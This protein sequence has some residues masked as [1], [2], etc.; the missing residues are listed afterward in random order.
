MPR[1]TDEIMRNSKDKAIAV[2]KGTKVLAS[3]DLALA[4]GIEDIVRTNA[5]RFGYKEMQTPTVCY[6][7]TL[8]CK[9]SEGAELADEIYSLTDRGERALGLRYDLTV[10][11]ARYVAENAKSLVFP[12]KRFECGEVFR[13]GPVKAG[14]MREFAQCDIDCVMQGYDPVVALDQIC[15]AFQVFDTMGMFDVKMKFSSRM[16]TEGILRLLEVGNE[17]VPAVIRVMDK[18]DKLSPDAFAAE[19]IDAGL[20]EEKLA[21]LNRWCDAPNAAALQ[22][23]RD[24]AP[25]ATNTAMPAGAVPEG[26]L[27]DRGIAEVAQMEAMLEYCADT[28]GRYELDVSL[29]RGQDYYTGLVC[30]FYAED[31][32]SSIAAGGRYDSLAADIAAAAGGNPKPLEELVGFGLSFGI[33]PL[34]EVVRSRVDD[35]SEVEREGVLVAGCVSQSDPDAPQVSLAA[36][37]FANKLRKAGVAC[38]VDV[39]TRSVSKKM[40]SANKSGYRFVVVFGSA[41]MT[42]ADKIVNVKDMC[43]GSTYA[44]TQDALFFGALDVIE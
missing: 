17:N 44:M 22:G 9:F 19:L 35:T 12:V 27:I 21:E 37:N 29:V 1:R 23:M 42:D 5:S 8:A 3:N 34:A 15:C 33:V 32:N 31:F 30:E 39:S 18:R 6:M 7:D 2:V 38:D 10:P 13:D 4:K 28:K 11:F 20:G 25:D 41:E 16:L 36:I 24:I 26:S 14:R 40:K 43:S